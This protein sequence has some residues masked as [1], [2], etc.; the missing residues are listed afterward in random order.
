MIN[1]LTNVLQD[2]QKRDR[3]L[4]LAG[5]FVC[6]MLVFSL[7]EQSD[8]TIHILHTS[9]DDMIPF[10]K[11]FIIPYGLWF[12][13]VGGTILYF[14]LK[15]GKE[16][17]FKQLMTALTFGVALFLVTSLIYPNGQDLRP[18][19]GG[20][21]IFLQAVKFLYSIDT[22]TNILPSLHVYNALVCTTAIFN[23]RELGAKEIFCGGVALY[24]VLVILST[25]FL[26]QHSIIDVTFG[27]FMNVAVNAAVYG[28]PWELEQEKTAYRRIPERVN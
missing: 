22:P 14:A 20:K 23:D 28:L 18:I 1:L 4:K 25:M 2:K 11:Y 17:E 16:Q 21:D 27:I 24:T 19:V 12:F 8:R 7:V 15:D 6:Y 3:I 5:Y 26:K 13:Y 9:V 10:C